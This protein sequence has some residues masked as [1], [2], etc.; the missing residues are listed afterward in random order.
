MGLEPDDKLYWTEEKRGVDDE[1]EEK[2]M[3]DGQTRQALEAGSDRVQAQDC[4]AQHMGRPA[5]K[6]PKNDG[7]GLAEART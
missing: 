1:G 6:V 7:L 3:E 5:S 4:R 2:R